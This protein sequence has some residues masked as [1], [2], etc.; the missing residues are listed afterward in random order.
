MV[1][2]ENCPYGAV[3]VIAQE[4]RLIPVPVVEEK[5]CWGCGFCEKHCPKTP[6]AIVVASR[7]ALRSCVPDFEAR[8]RAAGYKLQV[9]AL[10][11]SEATFRQ[12]QADSASA[13]QSPGRTSDL[14]AGYDAPPPGF[15]EDSAPPG[16]LEDSG[17][18][19]GFPEDSG[20]PPGFLNNEPASPPPPGFLP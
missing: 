12:G 20:P 8:G 16:F 11:G 14:E 1:C 5:R 15:L 10:P 2:K 18:P 13:G 19:P 9:T 7:N 4:G 3:D 6:S 17:P